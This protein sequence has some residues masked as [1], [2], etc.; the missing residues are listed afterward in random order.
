MNNI[1]NGV[2]NKARFLM[3]SLTLKNYWQFKGA[4]I[5]RK[6]DLVSVPVNRG[7][8]LL[9]KIKGKEFI[10]LGLFDHNTYSRRIMS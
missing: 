10:F 3:K 4:R 6:T 1:P 7:Y 8:R 9:Y 5:S 2:E